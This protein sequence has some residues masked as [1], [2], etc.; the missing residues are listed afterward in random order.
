MLGEQRPVTLLVNSA[1]LCIVL[2]FTTYING[3]TGINSVSIGNNILLAYASGISGTLMVLFISKIIEKQNLFKRLDYRTY[4][5]GA[6]IVVG[7]NL[8]MI[9]M[10]NRVVFMLLPEF[11]HTIITG[12]ITAIIIL[13]LCYP[14]IKACLKY[15]PILIGR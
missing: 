1:C 3:I 15:C 11:T 14:I 12:S 10:I 5:E 7:L 13:L 8:L 2:L 6:A 9:D 4:S